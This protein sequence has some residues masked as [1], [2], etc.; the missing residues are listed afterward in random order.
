MY[1]VAYDGSEYAKGALVRAVEYADL[2]KVNVE[3]LTIVPDSSR[4]ASERGW[5]AER[6]AYDLRRLVGEFHEQVTTIAPEA[7]FE[8]QTVDGYANAA[9]VAREIRTRALD[10]GAAVVFVGSEDAGSIVTSVS[11]VGRSVASEKEYDV[12]IV[13]TS[14]R[15]MT[16]VDDDRRQQW[17]KED[18][19]PK[20][21]W[22]G[23][24]LRH[25]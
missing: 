18:E 19:R 16:D 12:H 14:P 2:T 1:L 24:T 4:Y 20:P 3:A 11:S 5:I 13:R 9:H 10:E 15:E 23:D 22:G 7:S 6:D 17:L 8:Y 21:S 25:H